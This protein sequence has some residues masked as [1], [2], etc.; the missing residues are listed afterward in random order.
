MNW[1]MTISIVT[2]SV[3]RSFSALE[4]IKSH[5]Q[6]SQSEERLLTLYLISI[7]MHFLKELMGDREKFYGMVI[8]EFSKK[9]KR[10]E[11]LF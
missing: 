7:E 5:L 10:V 8:E 4:R 11:F 6:S 1:V 3:E 2:A 9:T